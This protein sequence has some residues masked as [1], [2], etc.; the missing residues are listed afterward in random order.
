MSIYLITYGAN[1][2]YW[3]CLAEN[4]DHAEEQFRNAY[5]DE[6]IHDLFICIKARW[7]DR[8]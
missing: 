8:K 2:E 1:N 6:Q 5:P 4:A 3:T 7:G